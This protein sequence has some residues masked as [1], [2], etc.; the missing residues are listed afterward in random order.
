MAQICDF[1]KKEIIDVAYVDVMP[2]GIIFQPRMTR[3]IYP[4]KI[5]IEGV[6]TEYMSDHICPNNIAVAKVAE[7]NYLDPA[8]LRAMRKADPL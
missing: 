3:L 7:E 4:Q 8:F 2:S 5:L 6:D 1:C